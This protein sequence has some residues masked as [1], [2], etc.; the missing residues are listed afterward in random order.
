MALIHRSPSFLADEEWK[1]IPWSANSSTKDSLHHLLD[2]VVDIPTYLMQSDRVMPSLRSDSIK[3]PA[4]VMS[5][6]VTLESW[7]AHLYDQLRW[8][9]EMWID[10]PPASQ[11]FEVASLGDVQWKANAKDQLLRSRTDEELKTSA[12]VTS[13]LV[14]FVRW[15]GRSRSNFGLCRNKVR[16]VVH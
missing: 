14:S 13:K 16:G 9:K 6:Q 5:M 2:V 8:W 1:S 10:T 7:V 15:H 4:K 12:D 3:D 11:P